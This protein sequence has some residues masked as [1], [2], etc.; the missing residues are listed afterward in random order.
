MEHEKCVRLR[1][2]KENVRRGSPILAVV[3]L[4]LPRFSDTRCSSAVFNV[5]LRYSL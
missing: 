5:V 2:H 4:Y 1:E 3:P